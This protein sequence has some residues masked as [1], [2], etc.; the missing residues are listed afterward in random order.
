MLYSLSAQLLVFY[1][2]LLPT[3]GEERHEGVNTVP[4]DT[5]KHL[6]QKKFSEITAPDFYMP[7]R[8]KTGKGSSV[9]P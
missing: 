7:R 5:V 9:K 8:A 1:Y 6:R 3:G 2:N 4:E